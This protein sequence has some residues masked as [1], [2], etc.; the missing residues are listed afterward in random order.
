MKIL[1]VKEKKT[2]R[3]LPLVDSGCGCSGAKSDSC[4]TAEQKPASRKQYWISGVMESP[5][6]QVDITDT[7]W[8]WRDYLGQAGCR[9]T[10]RRM[11][12]KVN[13]GLYAVGSPDSGSDI[14]VS[15][16]YKLSFDVLRRELKDLNAWILVLD[17][18]GIN[19]WCAAGKGTFGTDELIRRINLSRVGLVVKHRRIIVPQLGAP[20]ISA[21]TVK[22]KTGFTV[23]YGPV[24]AADIRKYVSDNYRASAEMRRMRFNFTDRLV[25][26]PMEIIPV[27]KKYPLFALVVLILFGLQPGGLIFRDAWNGAFPFLA[28]GLAS[29]FSGA[30]ITPVLLPFVPFRAFSVK[31][32][33]VGM[34]AAVLQFQYGLIDR[35]S[36]FL[37][38]ALFIFFPLASSYIA[39]QFTGATTFTGMTGVRRELRIGLPIYLMGTVLST[40]FIVLYKFSQWGLL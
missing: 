7:R 22:L 20:G 33:F 40:L 26:T 18:K 29:I 4:C 19:V 1:S 8:Q 34:A 27:M 2:R 9:L 23:K 28:A 6:G 12:Y 32:W 3:A 17:T 24:R 39:L 10:A 37:I 16:N 21:G 38:L 11:N 36:G 35:E 5:A 25:L 31:G 13:P 14:F 15:A 30:F